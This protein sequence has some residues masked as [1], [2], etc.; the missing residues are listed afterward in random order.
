LQWSG[1]GNTVFFVD[2]FAGPG[3]DKAG[4]PGSPIIAA[5]I[6]QQVRD[7]FRSTQGVL[8]VIAVEANP[9]NKA[10][11]DSLL[12]PFNSSDS[13][14]ARSFL[15]SV[16][17][18]ID[19]IIRDIHGGPALFF[20]DPFG[21]KGLDARSYPLMLGGAHNEILALFSDIGAVRLRGLVHANID[22][23]AELDALRKSPS[24]FPE[25]DAQVAQDL[26]KRIGRQRQWLDLL[27]PAARE[28]ISNALGESHWIDDLRDLPSQ[29]AR[30]ELIGRFVQR[31]FASG[32]GYV[33]VVPM[34]GASGAHKY[35]LVHASKSL[36]GFTT[37]KEVVSQSLNK[38]GLTDEMRERIRADLSV[39]LDDLLEALR[40]HFSTRTIRWSDQQVGVESVRRFLLE[41]TDVFNFQCDEIKRALRRRGWLTRSGRVEVCVFPQN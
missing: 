15:G 9:H 22:A 12:S 8:R 13:R 5:K 31:L 39:S 16:S 7:H 26:E 20:L 1:A 28:A 21:V 32:A 36:K 37:M 17:D 41:N 6:G 24:L 4:N 10:Q 2:G 23:T 11:L 14:C 38:G 29:E 18:H 34:R 25:F 35:C 27:E 33:L 40:S 19:A 3:Q 30:T